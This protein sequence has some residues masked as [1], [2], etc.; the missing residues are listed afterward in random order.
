MSLAPTNGMSRLES[1]ACLPGFESCVGSPFLRQI[2]KEMVSLSTLLLLPLS[3]NLL[4]HVLEI[5]RSDRARQG[6]ERSGRKPRN[7]IGRD[8][9]NIK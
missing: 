6:M 2:D 9:A 1:G 8:S 3:L 7:L 5:G 4:E